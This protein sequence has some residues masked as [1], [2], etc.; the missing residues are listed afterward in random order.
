MKKWKD[1]TIAEKTEVYKAVA[2]IYKE[3]KEIA[4]E[5][6]TTT[7]EYFSTSTGKNLEN[8]GNLIL[9]GVVLSKNGHGPLDIA[10][11]ENAVKESWDDLSEAIRNLEEKQQEELK[12]HFNGLVKDENDLGDILFGDKADFEARIV[13]LNDA[14]KKQYFEELVSQ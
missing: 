10:A 5:A 9:K 3:I 2:K 8:C 6:P 14:V 1:H 7:D 12:N 13:N 11:C 4:M